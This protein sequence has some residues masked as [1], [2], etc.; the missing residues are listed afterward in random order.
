MDSFGSL[1]SVQMT[2]YLSRTLE[3][4]VTSSGV[5]KKGPTREHNRQEKEKVLSAHTAILIDF[6]HPSA[7]AG[8][9]FKRRL[10]GCSVFRREEPGMY[11]LVSIHWQM[12]IATLLA[13]KIEALFL[14]I[15][16]LV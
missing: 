14:P 16:T 15:P 9:S 8:Q 6:L 11:L 5:V 1:H 12:C 4:F 13:L 10:S 7:F 3:T 2:E